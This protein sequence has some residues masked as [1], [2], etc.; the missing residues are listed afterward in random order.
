MRLEL[1]EA[2][3]LN[4]MSTLPLPLSSMLTVTVVM[5]VDSCKVDDVRVWN[6]DVGTADIEGLPEDRS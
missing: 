2:W 6:V 1:I 3:G 5:A 4:S